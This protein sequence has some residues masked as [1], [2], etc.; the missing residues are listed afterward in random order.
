MTKAAQVSSGKTH[1]DEN[2][3]VASALIAPRHRGVILA[4]YR[5]VRAADDVADHA[6]LSQAEKLALLDQ[7]EQGLLGADEIE[8]DAVALRRALAERALAPRHAQDLLTAF[9]MDVTKRRYRDWEDLIGY[10]SYSAM[11]VGRFVLDVHGESRDT[12]PANDA[13]CAALQIINHLQDCG[14]DYRNL[15]RVYVPL[16]ALAREGLAVEALGEAQASPALRRCLN[17][18][19]ER[20]GRLLREAEPFSAQVGDRRLGLEIA[21][22]QRLARTLTAMLLR[23]DPLSER[24]HLTKP[25]FLGASLFGVAEGLIRR[26]LPGSAAR[27]RARARKPTMREG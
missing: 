14:A 4:F 7:L 19:A 6:S 18:L 9:R 20:T 3:P 5:F 11:P 13:L 23:R 12:W 24:V 8:P 26:A 21:A 27:A 10:C 25:G 22:I 15:D 1:R 17:H 16:D 2:F